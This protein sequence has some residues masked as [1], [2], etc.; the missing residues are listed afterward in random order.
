MIVEF[1]NISKKIDGREILNDISFKIEKGSV[2]ALLGPNGA[3]KTTLIRHLLGLFTPNKGSIKLFNEQLTENSISLLKSK[4][5]VQNDGNLYEDLTVEQ[6]L[7]IW[8]KIYGMSKNEISYKIDELLKFFK[9]ESFKNKKVATLSKGMKQ[10][11]LISR[12]LIHEPELLILDEPMSGLD[13]SAINELQEHFKKLCDQKKISILMCTH[14]LDGLDDIITDIAIIN[15][16]HLVVEGNVKKLIDE[17][18]KNNEYYLEFENNK[19]AAKV[20]REYAEIKKENT[21]SC[22]IRI[23]EKENISNLVKKL[24]VN[25]VKIKEVMIVRHAVKDLYFDYIY[26]EGGKKYEQQD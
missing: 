14:Q 13:P 20:I 11:V 23:N 8:A 18:Y 22:L 12:A 10:K 15:K 24:A 1:E 16:G 17:K 21:G 25:D 26:N 5:G 2:F 6:N 7:F 19:L 9:L 4:I 3:G